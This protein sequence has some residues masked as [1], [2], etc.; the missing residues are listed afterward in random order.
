MH[1]FIVA[2]L[3]KHNNGQQSE[4]AS[5]F[6]LLLHPNLHMRSPLL[7]SHLY[8]K[9]AFSCS[10]IY[11]WT[12][13]IVYFFIGYTIYD[14]CGLPSRTASFLTKIFHR[15][16]LNNLEECTTT[17]YNATPYAGE[18]FYMSFCK[19]IL[20]FTQQTCLVNYCIYL[21]NVLRINMA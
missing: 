4:I 20:D 6:K 11:N 21:L 8:L 18:S 12:S 14:D 10:V 7:S 5:L 15:S 17:S 3:N 16:T 13:V 2:L 9:I 19:R 1:F